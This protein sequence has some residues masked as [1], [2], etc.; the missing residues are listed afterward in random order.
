MEQWSNALKIWGNIITNLENSVLCQTVNWMLGQNKDILKHKSWKI[1]SVLFL[2][3]LLED[4]YA[5]LN[6]KV[7]EGT[8]C[9][10]ENK[11]QPREKITDYRGQSQ[12]N[13]WTAAFRELLVQIGARQRKNISK[14]EG[15]R[16]EVWVD[17]FACINTRFIL[18]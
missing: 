16:L 2:R 10:S 4:V 15:N 12:N 13:S 7:N 9:D 11:F 17:V 6:E 8:M 18:L 5:S 1:H 14:R 3:I